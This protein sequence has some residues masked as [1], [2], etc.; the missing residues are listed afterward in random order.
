MK[1]FDSYQIREVGEV[2]VT[3]LGEMQT[4]PMVWMADEDRPNVERTYWSLYGW[5]NDDG[6]EVVADRDTYKDIA[7]LYFAITGNDCGEEPSD[8]LDLSAV[9][10]YAKRSSLDLL[11]CLEAMRHAVEHG[12]GA[13]AWEK[14]KFESGN[15]I[16]QAR[17]L[18]GWSA[19]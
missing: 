6:A 19:P 3:G 2:G 14:I 15:A 10:E 4:I 16:R 12:N 1:R 11:T 8:R 7:E 17:E 9:N 18:L 5:R 13:A